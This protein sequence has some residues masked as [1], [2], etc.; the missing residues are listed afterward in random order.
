MNQQ[1]YAATMRKHERKGHQMKSLTTRVII[2]VALLAGLN[3]QPAQ[4]WD[5]EDAYGIRPV[6]GW[7]IANIPFYKVTREYLIAN[8]QIYIAKKKR[9]L[10]DAR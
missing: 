2:L 1:I 8:N 3:I 4:A 7:T 6:Y 10:N 5:T 9:G